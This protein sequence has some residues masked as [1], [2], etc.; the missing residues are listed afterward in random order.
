MNAELKTFSNHTI[1]PV[2]LP[3]PP[4]VAGFKPKDRVI[5]L[6]RHA[7]EAL[8]MSA[9]KSGVR[10]DQLVKDENG[11]PQPSGGT[12]W[13]VT[14][15]TRYVAGVAAPTPTGID[16]ERIRS[17]SDGL[18]KKTASDSEWALADMA[19][20]PVA[21]FF[22]FWT[23]KEA[24]LKATGIGIKDLL[25]CRVH[26]IVDDNHLRIHYERKDWLIEHFVFDRHIAS[27]V[28][29]QYRIDWSVEQGL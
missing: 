17:F 2:I 9:E 24:V 8:Q 25:K 13:S 20:D 27:I 21:A 10:L 5:F 1:C 23:A 22:R 7:R 26:Q 28:Q 16:V 12:F 15:K 29:N 19:T 4:E 3:V 11:V 6:S 14:H 18:F